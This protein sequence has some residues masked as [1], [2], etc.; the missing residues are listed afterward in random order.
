M[1]AQDQPT[2]VGDYPPA[3]AEPPHLLHPSGALGVWFTDPAGMVTQFR[4]PVAGTVELASF[5]ARLGYA[6]LLELRGRRPT[7]LSFVHDLTLMT[8]YDTEARHVM[9]LWGLEI[10]EQIERVVVVRSREADQW[11]KFA[12]DGSGSA[13]VGRGVRFDAVETLE[14]ALALTK[15]TPQL[16]GR[17][18]KP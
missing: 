10:R 11:L 6:A 3:F 8:G 2:A 9:T 13:L 18:R 17:R 4:L 14:E 5:I 7:R 16:R 12:I 15:L 1:S